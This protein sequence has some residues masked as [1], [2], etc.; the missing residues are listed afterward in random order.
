MQKRFQGER[1]SYRKADVNYDGCKYKPKAT[2][3]FRS[4]WKSSD[5]SDGFL[6]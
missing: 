4:I 5:I 3:R 2:I 1:I 6:N